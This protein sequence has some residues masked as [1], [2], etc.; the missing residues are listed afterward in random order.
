MTKNLASNAFG[1]CQ[2]IFWLFLIPWILAATMVTVFPKFSYGLVEHWVC[3][4][5]TTIQPHG[6]EGWIFAVLSDDEA[7][8]FPQFTCVD[9]RGD[10]VLRGDQLANFLAYLRITGLVVLLIFPAEIVALALLRARAAEAAI[11]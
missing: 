10:V 8:D 9:S 7:F 6:T 4:A 2:L 11:D 1:G 3:P 5:D